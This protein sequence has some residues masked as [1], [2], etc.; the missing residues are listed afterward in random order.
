MSWFTRLFARRCAHQLCLSDLNL[1]GIEPP[2][3]PPRSAGYEAQCDHLSALWTHPSH[4]RRVSW[5][6]TKCGTVFYGHCGLDI[7]SRTR[8]TIAQKAPE[9]P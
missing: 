8:G 3:A 5:V 9:T 7:L 4:T 2:L 1:T 6:C